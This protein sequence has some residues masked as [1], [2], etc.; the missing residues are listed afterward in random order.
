MEPEPDLE[1]MVR[2]G[3]RER[4]NSM[5]DELKVYRDLLHWMMRQPNDTTSVR[6]YRFWKG[7]KFWSCQ[8]VQGSR[9]LEVFYGQSAQDVLKQA[10]E[11]AH[12]NK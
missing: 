7:A 1:W 9:G 12:R 2:A 4:T 3:E 11:W 8:M 10:A 6:W 5:A